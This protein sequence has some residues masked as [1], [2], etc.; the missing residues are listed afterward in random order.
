MS[1]TV[2]TN[3]TEA[4]ADGLSCVVCAEDFTTFLGAT[5]PVGVSEAGSQVFA[6]AVACAGTASQG[7]GE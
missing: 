1:A 7:G 3:L 5:V 4:Q 6:C 2:F